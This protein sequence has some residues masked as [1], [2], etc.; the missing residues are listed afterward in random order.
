[1]ALTKAEL[2]AI[3]QMLQ[4]ENRRLRQENENLAASLSKAT[5]WNKQLEE[6]YNKLREYVSA[7]S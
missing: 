1:M 6:H 2:E 7:R 4:E 3:N 5:A